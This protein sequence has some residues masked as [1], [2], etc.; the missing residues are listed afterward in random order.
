MARISE[1][2]YSNA[3]AS[4]SGIAEFLEV[5]LGAA[6][7]P[8][9][10]TVSFY[11]DDGALGF[12]VALDDPLVVVTSDP[13][14]GENIYTLSNDNL[15]ILLTD[16]DGSGV[17]NFEAYAL[18]QTGPGTPEVIDFY[19]IGGGTQNITALSGAAAGAV[20]ENLQ[21]PTGPQTSTTSIQFN[22]PNPDVVVFETISVGDTGVAC[23]T[24]G[25]MI[26]TPDGPRL[27]ETLVEGDLVETVDNGAQPI[28][29][30][31]AR[32][33]VGKGAHAPICIQKGTL[34]AQVDIRVSPLHRILLSGWRAELLF[35]A[36]EVL[37]SAKDLVNDDTIRPAP[38]TSVT[39]IHLLFDDHQIV[40]TQGV[41]SESFL[42]GEYILDATPSLVRDEILDLFPELATG[43]CGYGQSARRICTGQEAAM[44]GAEAL[45]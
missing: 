4:S 45:S 9:D 42:P 15:P 43:A 7:D 40:E 14:N 31:G 23:F 12:E 35:G 1:L 24:A 13:E 25:T 6:D 19:D 10:F 27:I 34:G 28:R 37:V 41:L 44:M 17:T 29:W 22:Q 11:E 38:C 30:A 18:T 21:P 33:V 2:H 39:Y 8:A 32:T 3:L 36:D 5:A 20:S 26:D 16:P